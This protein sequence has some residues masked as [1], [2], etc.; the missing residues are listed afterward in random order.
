MRNLEL[1]VKLNNNYMASEN[2][3]RFSEGL[4]NQEDI[5]YNCLEGRLKLR[6]EDD[7]KSY[8][9][10]YNRDNVSEAKV[11]TYYTYPI[12]DVE[13]FEKSVIKGLSEEL[14]VKK[15]RKLYLYK[16]ARIHIDDVLS[17]GK[18]LEIE[19]LIRD[20]NE[21][22][23]SKQLMEEIIA[24][25]NIEKCQKIDCGY[26]ELLLQKVGNRDFEYY[27][28]ANKIFWIVNDDVNENIE[29]NKVVPCIFVEKKD[30]EYFILQIDPSIKDDK[31]KYTIWRKFIGKIYNIRV[32]V[33]L[34]SDDNLYTLK[35]EKV[36]FDDLKRSNIVIDRQ[37]LAKFDIN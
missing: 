22:K 13:K 27:K 4:L 21:E 29:R 36:N 12:E 35:N 14:V 3:S 11:S 1:K 10:Y 15:L 24:L 9:I 2:L 34:I 19:I 23:E 20:E 17:L 26:R 30:D 28:N 25:C 5:Y 33:L 6:I 7:N 31:Y 37:Y 8:F 32:D 18:F 16:N